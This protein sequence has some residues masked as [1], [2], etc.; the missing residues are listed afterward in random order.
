MVLKLSWALQ[1]LEPPAVLLGGNQLWQGDLAFY[2]YTIPVIELWCFS[3]WLAVILYGLVSCARGKTSQRFILWRQYASLVSVLGITVV[4][5]PLAPILT[6]LTALGLF[7]R[8]WMEKCMMVN[9]AMTVRCGTPVRVALHA[10]D[11]AATSLWIAIL[12]SCGL[13]FCML[14]T[15]E[16]SLTSPAAYF[17]ILASILVGFPLLE[18]LYSQIFW[19]SCGIGSPP[20]TWRPA[21]RSGATRWNQAPPRMS[22]HETWLIMRHKSILSSYS[23]S[24]HPD[25]HRSGLLQRLQPDGSRGGQDHGRKDAS[26]ARMGRSIDM[27][28]SRA[29]VLEKA[30]SRN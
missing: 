8:Y 2:L 10:A 15:G 27:T 9:G 21:V 25:F 1:I 3:R 24:D 17:A 12:L 16:W 7:A 5:Q 22:Y 18:W 30:P 20:K 28:C 23:F 26:V 13:S 19:I 29:V 4:F 11:T 14:R 6:P